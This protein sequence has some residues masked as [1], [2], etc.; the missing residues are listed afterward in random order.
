[1]GRIKH[2]SQV[3]AWD[4]EVTSI[5]HFLDISKLQNQDTVSGIQGESCF[6]PLRWI[7]TLSSFPRMVMGLVD[8]VL[9]SYSAFL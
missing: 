8:A 5:F 2:N 1:M 6:Y 7:H 3:S 4:D 9:E